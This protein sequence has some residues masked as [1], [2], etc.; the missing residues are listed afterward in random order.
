MR[1]GKPLDFSRYEGLE[2]DRYILRSITDEIMYEIMRLSGQEYVDMYA[3]QAK[4]LA[5]KA[6]QEAK[7]LA[8][9]EA[10][11]AKAEKAAADEAARRGAA[12]D[13]RPASRR[14]EHSTSPARRPGRPG[15]GGRDRAEEGVLSLA[16]TGDAAA[17]A[18]VEGRLHRALVVVRLVVLVNAV[19]LNLYR[20]DNFERPGLAVVLVVVMVAWTAFA[21]WAYDDVR[22]RGPPLLV[23]DLAIAV[24]MMALTPLVKGPD[25]NATV[26]AFWVVGAL[27]A[28]AIHWRWLGGLVAA[29]SLSV[30]DL[31]IRDEVTQA[32]YGNVFLLMIAGPIVGYLCASLVAMAVARDEAL[33]AAAAAQ[34]RARLARAVHDGVLQV[35]ALVQRRGGE[36]GGEMAELG[37]LAGEQETQLRALIREQDTVAAPATH[38]QRDLGVDLERLGVLDRLGR[39]ARRARA[40]RRGRGEELVAVVRACLDNVRPTSV[41]TRPPGCCSRSS[42]RRR[43]QRPRRRARHPEGG[44]RR[45]RPR[46]GSASA[47]SIRGRVADLGGTGPARH[48]RRTAPSGKSLGGGRRDHPHS[49]PFAEPEGE[50]DPYV[51]SAAG[52]VAA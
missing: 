35:L 51:G 50:R 10:R 23:A 37:R 31:A 13:D 28:W 29:A 52:W 42:D 22:R 7:E 8:R 21:I 6:A 26:P 39:H 45:P 36:L 49:H 4:D 32:N 46:V 20:R 27:L 11:R 16:P 5:T 18:A 24:A 9:E 12:V 38:A 30:V 43:G 17:R 40:D 25:F 47:Q 41:R 48:R 44:S 15:Q 33:H 34:E 2:N 3:S 19:V 1:F 14:D